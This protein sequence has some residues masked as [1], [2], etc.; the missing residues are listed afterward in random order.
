MG[1]VEVNTILFDFLSSG[2]K[3]ERLNYVFSIIK[4]SN[5]GEKP[6]IVSMRY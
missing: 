6:V 5:M 1:R 2:G 3:R 4:G